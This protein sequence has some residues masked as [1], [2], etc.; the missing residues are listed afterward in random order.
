MPLLTPAQLAFVEAQRVGR[1][2]TA[3][4][5]AGPH[6]VPVCY[7]WGAESFYIALDSKPK[8]VPP[9]RLRRIRNI[10]ENPRVALVIDHYSDDWSALAYVLIRGTA[11]LLSPADAEHSQAITLLR[12]RYPQYRAMPIAE[13]PVIAIHPESVVAWG[14]L[15]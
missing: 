6:V 15:T 3:G 14:A 7:A 8:R 1:L 13:Q 12:R 11:R 10:V 5:A 4:H 9:E 2:A